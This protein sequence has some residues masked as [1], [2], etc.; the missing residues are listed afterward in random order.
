MATTNNAPTTAIATTPAPAPKAP[1]P[2]PKAAKAATKA[3]KATKAPKAANSSTAGS[4]KAATGTKAAKAAAPQAVLYKVGTQPPVRPGTHRAYAQA[5]AT[6][7]G[8][9]HRNGFT[10]AQYR[11]ALVAGVAAST[12]A[13]PNGGWAAHNMPTWCAHPN[14][15]WLVPAK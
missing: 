4:T 3:A 8:K 14:Q 12:I 9:K 13:P 5:I 11:A 6:A 1:A 7:L 2:A 15:Q 10:L